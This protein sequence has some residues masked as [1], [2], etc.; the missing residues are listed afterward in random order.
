MG[1]VI[2]DAGSEAVRRWSGQMP[3]FF[4]WLLW[5]CGLVSGTAIAVNT[6]LMAA[7]AAP[8]EWW[9]ELFPYLVGIPAGAAFACKFTVRGGMPEGLEEP[10]QQEIGNEV[11]ERDDF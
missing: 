6:A 5:L 7:G 9:Q 1:E 2:K 3:R 8:H 11:M 10:R 4:R